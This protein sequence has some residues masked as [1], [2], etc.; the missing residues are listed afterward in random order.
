MVKILFGDI[1]QLLNENVCL[2]THFDY[3]DKIDA[4]VYFAL[5]KLR[6]CGYKIV[7]ISTCKKLSKADRKLLRSFCHAAVLR[8]NIGLDFGGWAEVINSYPQLYDSENLL[9]ANDSVY[10]P[11]NDINSLIIRMQEQG[12][13]FWGATE[14]YQF[15]PHLQ[16][17]FINYSNKVLRSDVFKQFWEGF[18]NIDNKMELIQA[19]EISLT[20]LLKNHGF[21]YASVFNDFVDCRQMNGFSKLNP[22][23]HLWKELLAIYISP[24]IKVELL[25]NNPYGVDIKGV[26]NVLTILGY[27][28]ALIEQHLNRV[29]H[30]Y[31][32]NK[33]PDNINSPLMLVTR[34][35]QKQI[36]KRNKRMHSKYYKLKYIIK[37]IATKPWILLPYFKRSIKASA[38]SLK[39]DLKSAYDNEAGQYLRKRIS[40]K[41]YRNQR[42]SV[43]IGDIK[44]P[45]CFQMKQYKAKNNYAI[46]CHIY[47]KELYPELLPCIK[48]AQPADVFISLVKGSSDDLLQMV[49][50]DLPGCFVQVFDNH[51]RD[52]YPFL[53]FIDS[54]VLYQY[55]AILKIHSKQSIND[56][57][58]YDFD[59]ESWR[60]NTLK[61]LVPET[62]LTELLKQFINNKNVGI[63]CPEEYIYGLDHLGSNGNTLQMLCDELGLVYSS[64]N[65]KFPA[66]TMFW[67]KPWLLRH[68]EVLNLKASD[69]DMEPIAVDGTM[70]HAIE[71]L[72]GIITTNAGYDIV[73]PESLHGDKVNDGS[74]GAETDV[75]AY[76]LPQ[77]HPIPENDLWWGKGFTEWRNVATAKP[78]YETHYQPRVPADLGYYDLRLPEVQE[79]QAVIAE[80]YGLTAFAFYQYWF[81]G[82]KLLSMP[83]DHF[84]N[85]TNINLKFMLCWAN[86]NWTRSWDGLNKDVLLEQSY[87]AGWE[88]AYA[89]DVA[90]YLKSPKYYRRAGKPV[91]QI[92]NVSAIPDCKKCI[93]NLRKSFIELGVG[94]IE[95]LA[96]LFYGVDRDADKYGV[97][98]FSEFPPHRLVFIGKAGN[99]L[100]EVDHNFNGNIYSYTSV[101]KIKIAEIKSRLEDNIELG[102]MCG[103]DNT[104]RRKKTADIF[105]GSTPAVFRE[106]FDVAYQASMKRS[107]EAKNSIL[108]VNAWNEWAE[109]TYLEPDIKYGYGY[110]EAIKSVVLN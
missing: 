64:L 47:Y 29:K 26:V 54:G 80:N 91:L 70:A 79:K 20:P 92:Y 61:S 51:G 15:Q 25:R 43:Q 84:Y 76:Y 94:E 103:W 17:Y 58:E 34:K 95:I 87:D 2:Y 101:S 45:D 98:G 55:E 102:V 50:N 65:L 6:E 3:E 71:R 52:I 16:S 41:I 10:G 62:G 35:I 104:A 31:K 100:D 1:T 108:F 72:I 33:N 36:L 83:I 56:K 93:Q 37:L 18:K 44:E 27:D 28:Y 89:Q 88:E 42:S 7:F 96:V 97:D 60:K 38:K 68:I 107:T 13:D 19:Y 22:V 73:S 85:N 46:I 53:K 59:G 69:F 63:L 77:F 32:D 39:N 90:I 74:S 75:I 5:N 12:C 78:Q 49:Q 110:L 82:K 86:E 109:G 24:F 81:S 4:Y 105:H 9:L 57:A 11:V 67:I 40:L 21:S 30:Y 99:E 8:A 14:S 23:H 106:W 48:R 66:G